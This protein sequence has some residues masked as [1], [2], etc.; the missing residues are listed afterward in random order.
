MEFPLTTLK[1]SSSTVDGRKPP[2]ISLTSNGTPLAALIHN[3]TLRLT[4][5]PLLLTFT[6]SMQTTSQSISFLNQFCSL[7]SILKQP[8]RVTIFQD[9]GLTTLQLS[10]TLVKT[11]QLS[12]LS[13]LP[14][15]TSLIN[16][17]FLIEFLSHF[18][19]FS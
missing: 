18:L 16:I 6:L 3:F 15:S 2:A 19:I 13:R 5:L 12:S 8:L 9:L 17:F 14:T 7:H 11:A 10:N 4:T 1:I